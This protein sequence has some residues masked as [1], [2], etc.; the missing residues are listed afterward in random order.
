[1]RTLDSFAVESVDF[2]KID[3][4]GYEDR[5]IEGASDTIKR[6]RPTIIVEQKQHIM[7][8]TFGIKGTPAVDLLKAMDARVVREISGDF[9]LVFD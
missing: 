1:M 2:I 7:S 8:Q 4:E 6:C 3:C 5:V 9:I